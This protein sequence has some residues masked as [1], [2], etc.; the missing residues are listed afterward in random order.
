MTEENIKNSLMHHIVSNN[1]KELDIDVDGICYLRLPI[2]TGLITENDDLFELLGKHVAPH[3]LIGDFIFIS[4]KVVALTQGQIIN[5]ND[6]H[7]SKFA[8]FLAGKVKN[9]YGTKDFR[10]FG[11]GTPVAMQ[12]LIDQVGYPRTFFAAAVSAITRPFG[13]KGA[14]YLICG[15]KGKSVDCPMSFLIQPYTHFAKLPPLNPQRV[16]REVKERFGNETVIIDANYRGAFT[17]GISSNK[18]KEKFAQKVFRD[19]PLG[20]GDELT[21]FC[22]VRKK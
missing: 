3:L 10:G 11:H 8:R 5:I 6:V 20:Q 13:I 22:I 2:K 17:L 19:N 14:F 15:K 18:I 9:N 16:A 1:G 12:L 21:P 4:E 7:P